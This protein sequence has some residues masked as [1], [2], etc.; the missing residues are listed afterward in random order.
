MRTVKDQILSAAFDI[1]EKAYKDAVRD[2]RL[3]TRKL[4]IP[5]NVLSP[6][7]HPAREP[8][9]VAAIDE[10]LRTCEYRDG[11]PQLPDALMEYHL[12]RNEWTPLNLEEG[13]VA[14]SANKGRAWRVLSS[15]EHWESSNAPWLN[16]L[17]DVEDKF[18]EMGEQE[19]VK[20]I[21]KLRKL[22]GRTLG[23][24]RK[25]NEEKA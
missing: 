18:S 17:E 12:R 2:Y 23:L 22:C 15:W 16:R 10:L 21:D 20:A 9:V 6:E 7:F 25:G 11:D 24:Y 5:A 8:R 14:H 3:K 1:M 4:V 13:R 19:L